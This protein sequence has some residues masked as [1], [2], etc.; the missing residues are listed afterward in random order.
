[1]VISPQM[2]DYDDDETETT[3]LVTLYVDG[4]T[5]ATEK[6]KEIENERNF[7]LRRIAELENKLGLNPWWMEDDNG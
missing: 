4:G 5:Q 7:L 6:Q 3:W 2:S 1:V